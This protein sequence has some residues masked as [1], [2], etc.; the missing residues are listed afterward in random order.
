MLQ[1]HDDELGVRRCGDSVVCLTTRSLNKEEKSQKGHEMNVHARTVMDTTHAL[2]PLATDPEKS[3][4]I[5]R[6]SAVSEAGA[7]SRLALLWTD[8]GPVISRDPAPP[9]EP[10]PKIVILARLFPSPTSFTSSVFGA[11][12]MRCMIFPPPISVPPLVVRVT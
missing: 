6:S 11:T 8:L 9:E 7:G 10:L 4:T 3:C 2:G 5:S 1:V 12:S